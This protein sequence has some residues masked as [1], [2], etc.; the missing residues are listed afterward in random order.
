MQLGKEER[1]EVRG[2]AKER[3]R[4]GKKRQ[5]GTECKRMTGIADMG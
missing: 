4:E 2:G 3:G 5:I 1:K